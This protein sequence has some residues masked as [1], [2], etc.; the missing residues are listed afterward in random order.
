[1]RQII[2]K[3]FHTYCL[4][5]GDI[6][7]NLNI[8]NILRILRISNFLQQFSLKTKFINKSVKFK[9]YWEVSWNMCWIANSKDAKV[10]G[11]FWEAEFYSAREKNLLSMQW[12][13]SRAFH[14]KFII[15]NRK[16]NL[17]SHQFSQKRKKMCIETTI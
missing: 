14:I 17:V 6:S 12:K 8:L 3:C 10:E 4:Y 1:M 9:T 5:A 2:R 13:H 16:I 7:I 11:N 15:G